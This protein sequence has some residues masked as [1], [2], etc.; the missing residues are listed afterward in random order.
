M[1]EE[2]YVGIAQQLASMLYSDA[3]CWI[4]S[5]GG[6]VQKLVHKMRMK[7]FE[8]PAALISA[9]RQHEIESGEQVRV[10][11]KPA[12]FGPFLRRHFLTPLV[13]HHTA[14]RIGPPL[15][16]QN[17]VLGLLAQ[18]TSHLIPV[19]LYPPL[20]DDV[21]QVCLYPPDASACGF[22]G[23]VPG[24]NELV[25]HFYALMSSQ[26]GQCFGTPCWTTGVVRY[27]DA[28]T[29]MSAGFSLEDHEVIR[30]SG[31]VWFL[32]GTG[33]ESE[34]EPTDDVLDDGLWGGLYASGHLELAGGAL[35]VSPVVEAI[36]GAFEAEGFENQLSRN[37]A[38]RR[39]IAIFA[40]GIRATIDTKVP[41]Y[42]VHMDAEMAH[43]FSR[44]RRIFDRVMD[45]ILSNLKETCAAESVELINEFDLDFSYTDSAKAYSVL[46]SVGANHIQD[47]IA[48]AIRDWHRSRGA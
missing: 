48:V 8:S 31:R 6:R 46:K 12:R 34:V 16:S 32:D 2:I 20:D 33:D 35:Q 36:R 30:Q 29:L 44:Y 41:F 13:G 42:S 11:C 7:R 28:S 15:L 1:S 5:L 39:E 40:K 9:I 14:H 37:R 19:G 47:P 21:N 25:P 22:I 27:I 24:V 10:R 45:D 26:Y 17:P 38:G 3:K 23:L 43:G 4:A 18:A